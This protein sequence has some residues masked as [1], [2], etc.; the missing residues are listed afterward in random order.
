MPDLDQISKLR[1]IVVGEEPSV[2]L[3]DL[4][5]EQRYYLLREISVKRPAE[6]IVHLSRKVRHPKRAECYSLF[7]L[8]RNLEG[9]TEDATVAITSRYR[10]GDNL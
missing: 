2:D 5:V 6:T 7:H 3:L 10:F 9:S 4:G 8:Q 1:S